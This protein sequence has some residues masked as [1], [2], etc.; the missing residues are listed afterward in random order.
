[1]HAQLR[2]RPLNRGAGHRSLSL[3]AYSQQLPPSALIH[4]HIPIPSQP[5]I[6]VL[7]RSVRLLHGSL[8]DDG[9]DIVLRGE[10]EHFADLGRRTDQRAGKLDAPE[11]H[12]TDADGRE[13]GR[14]DLDEGA[15]GAE[16]REVLI[17]WHLQKV[18]SQP[19][20]CQLGQ[21]ER[22]QEENRVT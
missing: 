7:N 22:L 4:Q 8:L 12:H 11:A 13:V 19:D 16:E 20:S 1:M 2:A 21:D 5:L 9:M 3:I 15:V 10:F 17:Q 6:H 14:S 18:R